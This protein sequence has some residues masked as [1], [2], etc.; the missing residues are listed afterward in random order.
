MTFQKGQNGGYHYAKILRQVRDAYLAG[1]VDYGTLA[2]VAVFHDG[3]RE[4]IV[5]T[6][7]YTKTRMVEWLSREYPLDKWIIHTQRIPDTW[8]G[9]ELWVEFW[10]T[11][12]DEKALRKWIRARQGERRTGAQNRMALLERTYPSRV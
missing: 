10:G 11:A 5:K 3:T 1:Q 6:A 7:A 2:K 9:S 8:K 12:E 4:H